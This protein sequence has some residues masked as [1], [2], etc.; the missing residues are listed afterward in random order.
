MKPLSNKSLIIPS[1]SLFTSFGTLICCAL[2]SLFV[3]I[4]AGALLV[5]LLSKMLFLI[6]LSKYKTILFIVSG[7]LIIFSGLLIWHNKNA[8]CPADPMKAKAR[9]LNRKI[10][11]LVY[12]L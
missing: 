9:N 4:G 2:P 3:A 8:P 10:S 6:V 11:I 1:L 7:I 5:G 12:F